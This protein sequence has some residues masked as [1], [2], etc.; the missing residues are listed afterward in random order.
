MIAQKASELE[1][2][3]AGSLEAHRSEFAKMADEKTEALF[4][5][6]GHTTGRISTALEEQAAAM[7]RRAQTM[8]DNVA[9]K[10]AETDAQMETQSNI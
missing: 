1:T 2:K 8:V 5:A 7:E 6:V 9:K 10:L 4:G 3:L